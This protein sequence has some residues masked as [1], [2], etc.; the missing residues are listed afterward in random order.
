MF[1]RSAIKNIKRV[2]KKMIE[3]GWYITVFLIGML[4]GVIIGMLRMVF[5]FRKKYYLV[6][7]TENRY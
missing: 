7:K 3:L 5:Y 6:I 1:V 4:I 2:I